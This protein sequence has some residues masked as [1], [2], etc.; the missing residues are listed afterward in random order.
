MKKTNKSVLHFVRTVYYS[1]RAVY[2]N[3]RNVIPQPEVSM[4]WWVPLWSW[5][6]F[7]KFYQG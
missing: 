6:T 1:I 4:W 7:K 2:L 5:K 3:K